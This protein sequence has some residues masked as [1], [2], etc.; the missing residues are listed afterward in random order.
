MVTHSAANAAVGK[1]IVS[2]LDGKVV[3]DK[4]SGTH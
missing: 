1:R 3:S 2:L 4:S